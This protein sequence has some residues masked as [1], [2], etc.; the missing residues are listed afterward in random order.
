MHLNERL[1]YN[2]RARVNN[3]VRAILGDY[4]KSL[5]AVDSDN[6]KS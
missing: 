6:S 2:A 1:R 4:G 5:T 3:E